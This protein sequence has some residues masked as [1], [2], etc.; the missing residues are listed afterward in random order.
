MTLPLQFSD[1]PRT[2]VLALTVVDCAGGGGHTTVVGGTSILFFGK[3][4][5]YR[6]GMYDLR[7]WPNRRADGN[8]CTKTPGKTKA[9][10]SEH[11]MER[12]AKLSKKHHNGQIPTVDWLDR[13]TF[14]EIEVI[15]EKEKTESDH[16][17]LLVEFQLVQTEGETVGGME[18]YYKVVQCSN[19]NLFFLYL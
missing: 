4:G 2:A 16:L 9:S 1:L 19:I 3:N 10:L 12:L 14:R 8:L 11:Q 5:M 18:A 6:Q 13:L 7:V 17:Y 15:N